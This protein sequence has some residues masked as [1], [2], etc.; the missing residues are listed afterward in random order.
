MKKNNVIV[1][2]EEALGVLKG[3]LTMSASM[4]NIEQWDSLGHLSIL[5]ALDREFDGKI[6][7]IS[8]IAQA[9]SVKKILDIL[10]ENKLIT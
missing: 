9:D 10:S 3:E 4:E 5:S 8:N 6:A 7:A 2:I 1:I